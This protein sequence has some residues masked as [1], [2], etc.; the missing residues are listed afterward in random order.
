M[1]ELIDFLRLNQLLSHKRE[2]LEKT[3]AH[4]ADIVIKKEGKPKFMIEVKSGRSRREEGLSLLDRLIL[5]EHIRRIEKLYEEDLPN[6]FEKYI[7]DWLKSG[8]TMK[9]LLLKL[10][11]IEGRIERIEEMLREQEEQSIEF[12]ELPKEEALKLIRE[13]VK[14]HPGCLTSEIIEE[15]GLDPAIV[16]EVLKELEERGEVESREPE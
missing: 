6:I 15:L 5:T 12:K 3:R 2:L 8:E 1:D 16:I 7:T 10:K 4:R 11:E 13:Y 9:A 14:S